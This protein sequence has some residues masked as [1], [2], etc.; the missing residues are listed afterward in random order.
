MASSRIVVPFPSDWRHPRAV[1]AHVDDRPGRVC[2]HRLVGGG[3]AH[4]LTLA[5]SP[6]RSSRRRPA[7]RGPRRHR[8]GGDG[9][10]GKP[11]PRHPAGPERLRR[12][13][14]KRSMA[15]LESAR[16][17][18]GADLV[19]QLWD[20]RIERPPNPRQ[21]TEPH[22][23]RGLRGSLFTRV[24][25][26]TLLPAPTVRRR[27]WLMTRAPM[28]APRPASGIGGHQWHA[29]GQ[30]ADDHHRDQDPLDL[31]HLP[32][33]PPNLPGSPSAAPVEP[34]KARQTMSSPKVPV[35]SQSARNPRNALR[36]LTPHRGQSKRTTTRVAWTSATT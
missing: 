28:V 4:D 19:R 2:R 13:A 27:R 25:V 34:R 35:K 36:V 12:V 20:R 24:R 22:K 3:C 14:H 16:P 11:A 1:G 29:G 21:L 30:R 26:T 15:R 7:G 32:A 18:G 5:V 10:P 8:R 23:P 33:R 6:R 9:R 17:D 31:A